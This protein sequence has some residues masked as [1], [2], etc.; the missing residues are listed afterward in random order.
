MKAPFAQV[1]VV[2]DNAVIA[3]DMRQLLQTSVAE[4]TLAGSGEQAL[5][6][7]RE[8][9]FD[10]ILLNIHL[11]G[12]SGLEVCRRLK[13]DPQL[14]AI[15][16]IFVSGECDQVFVNEALRLG[17][18]D[19]LTKPYDTKAFAARVLAHLKPAPSAGDEVARHQSGKK[20]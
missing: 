6:L 20:S 11:P 8:R 5:T 13:L 14:K 12:I 19:Y 17:A 15:P 18:V 3:F 1:L 7:V 16:V 2:D 4:T 9:R 10:L